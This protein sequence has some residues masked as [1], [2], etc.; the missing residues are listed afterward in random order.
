[1]SSFLF[2][3]QRDSVH[4]ACDAAAYNGD[5]GILQAVNEAKCIA[6]PTLNAAISCVGPGETNALFA[7]HMTQ[8]FQSFDDLVERAAEF[9]P[10]TFEMIAEHWRGGDASASLALIGWHERENRPAAYSM[11]LWTDA[12][13]RIENVLEASGKSAESAERFVLKEQVLGGTP[14][15]SRQAIAA[16]G[17]QIPDDENDMRPDI[18]LLH[19]MEVQRQA[20]TENDLH[21][22]GGKCLLT[23]I[24]R[25]GT[26]QRV[27]HRWAEDEVGNIVSPVAI[28]DWSA[29]RREHE[30]RLL[31]FAIP[32]GMSRLKRE[33]LEKKLRKGTLRVV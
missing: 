13:S 10:Q 5:T 16:A 30:K 28:T 22:V 33:M 32:E 18:D 24:D 26:M 17:L 23:S 14:L 8:F 2:L 11:N 12:S 31:P 21:F 7:T 27:I 20:V 15:P 25:S 1:M 3:R 4:L 6:I 9:F 29:W 19:L